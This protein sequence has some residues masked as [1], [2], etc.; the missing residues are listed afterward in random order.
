MVD[1]DTVHH[2]QALL[3]G[4][5]TLGSDSLKTRS[6]AGEARDHVPKIVPGDA[7][8]FDVI[9]GRTRGCSNAPAEQTD[10]A[11]IIATR[12]ISQHHFAAGII[13]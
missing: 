4:G 8:E 11:E 9:E 6:N 3:V 2:L 5:A 7:N 12:E 10:F 1:G 13:L